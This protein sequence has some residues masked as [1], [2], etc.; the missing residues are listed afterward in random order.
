MAFTRVHITAFLGLAVI[1][2]GSVLWIQGTPISWDHLAPFS[3]V[4]AVLTTTAIALEHAL[5]RL[6]C[7]HGWFVKRPDLR[8]TWK[9][10]LHPGIDPKTGAPVAPITAFM[11]VTQT[12]STLQ[13]HL[14]TPESESWLIA[15][16]IRSSPNG[17]GYQVAAVYTNKPGVHL[18]G[19]RSEIHH[20][21]L[22]LDAHGPDHRPS[23][24]TGEYWTD[25]KTL[26]RMQLS[27]RVPQVFTRFDEAERAHAARTPAS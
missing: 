19:T 22:V 26:G 3:S 1:A 27:E 13:M 2:W 21:A 4:V 6:R 24:L 23:S 18:R 17:T 12:L 10:E 20:G 11:G 7:F 25:R 16:R 9:V 14:M 5:W 8:G 15:D